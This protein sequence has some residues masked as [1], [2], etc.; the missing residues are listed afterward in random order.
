[1]KAVGKSRSLEKLDFKSR[2]RNRTILTPMQ[3]RLLNKHYESDAFPNTD[4]REM[5]AHSLAM[6]QRSVQIWFQNHRQKEKQER[7]LVLMASKRKYGEGRNDGWDA[8]D[9]LARAAEMVEKEQLRDKNLIN[10]GK[11]Q[12]V[13]D[14]SSTDLKEC[15]KL[16]DKISQANEKHHSACL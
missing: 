8:L 10:N 16:T 15:M 6:T 9:M 2:K 7:K 12:P 5:I 3:L 11:S 14:S 4:A 13:F 1:M